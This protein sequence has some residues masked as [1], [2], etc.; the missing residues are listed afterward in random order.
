MVFLKTQEDFWLKV[1]QIFVYIL[2]VTV[3]SKVEIDNILYTILFMRLFVS[4]ILN[5]RTSDP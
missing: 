5:T 4:P 3:F 2:I 1:S